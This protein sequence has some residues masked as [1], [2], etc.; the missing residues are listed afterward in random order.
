MKLPCT[1]IVITYDPKARQNGSAFKWFVEIEWRKPK[2]VQRFEIDV[3]ND[4]KMTA[5]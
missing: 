2:L 5:L 4:D 1:S 3:G